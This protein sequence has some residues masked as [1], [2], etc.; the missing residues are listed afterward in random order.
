MTHW[1]PSHDWSKYKVS[2]DYEVPENDTLARLYGTMGSQPIRD[3]NI[4]ELKRLIEK[5]H[6]SSKER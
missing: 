1:K 5:S 6:S 3:E 2:D 4:A